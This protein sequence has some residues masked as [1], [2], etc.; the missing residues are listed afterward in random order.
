MITRLHAVDGIT[1]DFNDSTLCF[2]ATYIG[3]VS[4]ADF[5]DHCEHGLTAVNQKVAAHG[6][7]AWLS[8]LRKSEIFNDE[9][10]RWVNEYWNVQVYANGLQYLALVMAESTFAAINIEDFI[11]EHKKRKDPLTIKLFSDMDSAD[12]WCK[13]MLAR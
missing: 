1:L 11:D 10:V 2:L 8:D 13:E 9:D 3:F 6:K 7:V 12:A 4:S 5:H